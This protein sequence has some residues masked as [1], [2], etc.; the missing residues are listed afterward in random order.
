MKKPS[1]LAVFALISLVGCGQTPP[2]ASSSSPAASAGAEGLK[3][4]LNALRSPDLKTRTKAMMYVWESS[5]RMGPDTI[6]PMLPALTETVLDVDLNIRYMAILSLKNFGRASAPA[7]PALIKALDTFPGRTPPLQGP[8]RYYADVRWVAADALGAIGPGAKAAVPALT[9][10]LK[11][12]SPDVREAA[13][14]ALKR[15]QAK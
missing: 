7:V 9:Q 11:D 10:A 14:A 4:L 12:A 3:P 2:A 8:E 15:I 5:P 6:E 1:I 13:A